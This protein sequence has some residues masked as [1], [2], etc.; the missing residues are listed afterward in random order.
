MKY[1]VN[2]PSMALCSSPFDSER[3]QKTVT[4]QQQAQ[5]Q[6]L[7]V[8]ENYPY[9]SQRA[10]AR[11]AGISVG[12]VNFLIHALVEKGLLKIGKFYKARNKLSKIAYILTPEGIGLRIELTQSY[13]TLKKQQL[14]R[15]RAEIE[16]L[17]RDLQAH[18]PGPLNR[19]T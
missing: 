18:A 4:P 10:L 9:S 14:D 3:I 16:V 5:F 17:E 15:L 8:I 7:N 11:S 12:N 19:Q 1:I 2:I 13:L 6:L